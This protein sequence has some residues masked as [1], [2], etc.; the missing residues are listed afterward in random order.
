[1]L[2]ITGLMPPTWASKGRAQLPEDA[3]VDVAGRADGPDQRRVLALEHGGEAG[4]AALDGL[5]EDDVGLV[6]ARLGPAGRVVVDL[7][8]HGGPLRDGPAGCR[9]P[10]QGAGGRRRRG[11]RGGRLRLLAAA[12]WAGEDEQ[13]LRSSPVSPAAASTPQASGCRTLER[14]VSDL[15]HRWASIV[16]GPRPESG[17]IPV[18]AGRAG[19]ARDAARESGRGGAGGGARRWRRPRCRRPPS[20]RSNCRTRWPGP[21]RSG[22]RRS[23]WRGGSRR[24]PREW[25]G[26]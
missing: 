24:S 2:A 20:S 21:G 18:A 3:D 15:G 17:G 9:L 14:S 6:E 13:A 16:R 5:L 7:H 1:M 8:R 10:G 12:S 26:R 23:P 22:R 25:R 19:P 4:D 11:R